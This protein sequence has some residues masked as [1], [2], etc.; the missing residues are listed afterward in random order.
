MP[1]KCD[2]IMPPPSL[3]GRMREI[4][5]DDGFHPSRL[6]M[7][8]G[9]GRSS[10]HPPSELLEQSLHGCKMVGQSV[11]KLC[12]LPAL[13]KPALPSS[14][15]LLSLS[16]LYLSQS[17]SSHHTSAPYLL[18]YYSSHSLHSLH[19]TLL[20]SS[21]SLY[22]SNYNLFTTALALSIRH[23]LTLLIPHRTTPPLTLCTHH[24]PPSSQ[25]LSLCNHQTSSPHPLCHT[26]SRSPCSPTLPSLLVLTSGSAHL[27]VH[28][29]VE[30]NTPLPSPSLPGGERGVR[31]GGGE[32][33]PLS[34]R[35]ASPTEHL[36]SHQDGMASSLSSASPSPISP[37][38]SQG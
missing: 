23:T 6:G 19:R 20:T 2:K 4:E 13:T 25:H 14:P 1:R 15:H 30:V 35:R 27:L 11:S 18:H 24:S 21:R 29:Q 22:S 28:Q 36:S 38:P 10:P 17:S 5:G 37:T 9:E 3:L 33:K 32:L 26:I 16:A 8:G 34:A 7:G 31:S 12:R